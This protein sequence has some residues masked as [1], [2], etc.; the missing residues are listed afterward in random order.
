[1]FKLQEY[2]NQLSEPMQQK[3]QTCKD[4]KTAVPGVPEVITQKTKQENSSQNAQV[5]WETTTNPS[6]S[7]ASD[8]TVSIYTLICVILFCF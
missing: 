8:I 2:C 3:F 5:D 7:G 1:M 6:T 4:L